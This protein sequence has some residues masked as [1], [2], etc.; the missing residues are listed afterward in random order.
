MKRNL[1]LGSQKGE[2]EAVMD[3]KSFH[4]FII[5]STNMNLGFVDDD[6]G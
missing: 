4:S 3:V 6:I 5:Y 2:G 1:K